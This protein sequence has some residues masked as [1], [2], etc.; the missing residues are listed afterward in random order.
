MARLKRADCTGP[1]LSRRRRGK[2]F[3]Y[4][5]DDGRRIT[6]PDVRGRMGELAIPAAWRGV[7]IG[8]YPMG[9]IHATGVDAAGRKQDLYHQKWRELQ[10]RKKFDAMVAFAQPLPDMRERVDRD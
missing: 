9:H 10:D 6:E 8:P 3:E 7:W 4:L 5:D 2:G 1:G